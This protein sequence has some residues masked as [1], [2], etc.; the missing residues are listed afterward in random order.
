MPYFIVLIIENGWF[1]SLP[2]PVKPRN[3]KS[4]RLHAHFVDQAT[5]ELGQCRVYS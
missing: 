3:N 1:A 5:H 2:Q 4:A